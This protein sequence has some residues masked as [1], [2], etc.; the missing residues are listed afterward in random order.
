MPQTGSHSS[1][2]CYLTN[3]EKKLTN[4]DGQACSRPSKTALWGINCCTVDFPAVHYALSGL[5]LCSISK[6]LWGFNQFLS[7]SAESIHQ[8]NR[9]SDDSWSTRRPI[10][11]RIPTVSSRPVRSY[12]SNLGN[13]RE[14]PLA[15]QCRH[16]RFPKAP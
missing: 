15:A 3:F 10:P 8:Q 7:K 14:A 5:T 9:T 13:L 4:P 12:A 6:R 1:G 2:D 11:S 16:D